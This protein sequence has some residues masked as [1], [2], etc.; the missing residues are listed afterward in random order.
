MSGHVA[1]PCP[2][3]V[4]LWSGVTPA[5][6]RRWQEQGHLR[7][8]FAVLLSPSRLGIQ[9]AYLLRFPLIIQVAYALSFYPAYYPG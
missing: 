8:F 1:G 6:G 9:V 4:R 2:A 3:G 5:H 7:S